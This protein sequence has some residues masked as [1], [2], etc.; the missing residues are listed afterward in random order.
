[1]RV[2]FPGA[3]CRGVSAGITVSSLSFAF[4]VSVKYYT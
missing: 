3:C 1:M 4:K 2:A